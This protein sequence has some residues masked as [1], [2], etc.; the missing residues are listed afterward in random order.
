MEDLQE[1]KTALENALTQA[2]SASHVMGQNGIFRN[3]NAPD[4]PPVDVDEPSMFCHL[5]NGFSLYMC[6]HVKHMFPTSGV[7]G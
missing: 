6:Y 7:Q 2:P 3:D 4:A 5:F 1:W